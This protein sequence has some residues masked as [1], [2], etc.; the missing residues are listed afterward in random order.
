MIK[1]KANRLVFEFQELLMVGKSTPSPCIATR[2]PPDTVQDM[3][4]Y[5]DTPRIPGEPA[6]DLTFTRMAHAVRPAFEAC[7]L[8]LTRRFKAVGLSIDT[9]V[10]QMPRGL[11]TFLAL[12]GKR[13]LVCIVEITLIDGME[14][15]RGPCA[16]LE[17][18]LLDACGDVVVDGFIGDVKM[19]TVQGALSA[20]VGLLGSLTRAATG[21]YVAALAQFDLLR[22]AA[23]YA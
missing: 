12:V 23:R 10:R 11:S 5:H 13:G 2:R 8:D 15:G 16:A 19:C 14:I 7:T 3:N 9:Q 4:P 21:V 18:R 20:E 17:L 1:K 6:W 22:P